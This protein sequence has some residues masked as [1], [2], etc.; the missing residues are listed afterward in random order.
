M[1]LIDA[2]DFIEDIK[3][4]IINLALDG[5]KGKPRPIKE[6]YQ[7][8]DRINEQPTAYDVEKVVAELHAFSLNT[9]PYCK[10]VKDEYCHEFSDCDYCKIQKAI[11]IVHKGGKE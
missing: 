7:I 9:E 5:L 10:E 3:T 11:E 8:I 2:D 6:L 4:E 1:R